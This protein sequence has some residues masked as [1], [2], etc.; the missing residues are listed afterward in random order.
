MTA[1]G[2]AD[3][4]TRTTAVLAG[5]FVILS[6]LLAARIG[7]GYWGHTPDAKFVDGFLEAGIRWRRGADKAAAN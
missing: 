6:I 4:L 3:F 5:I 2:A 7:D 1:R